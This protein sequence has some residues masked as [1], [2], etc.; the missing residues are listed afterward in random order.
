MQI[1]GYECHLATSTVNRYIQKINH[2]WHSRV[3]AVYSLSNLVAYKFSEGRDA[4]RNL[5][6]HGNVP[7]ALDSDVGV[8]STACSLMKE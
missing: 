5:Y 7:A 8:A 6:L 3:A 4:R 2:M 1:Y